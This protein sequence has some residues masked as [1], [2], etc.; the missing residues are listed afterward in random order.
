MG[1]KWDLEEDFQA[2]LATLTIVE[3]RHQRKDIAE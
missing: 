1:E 2:V 3:V